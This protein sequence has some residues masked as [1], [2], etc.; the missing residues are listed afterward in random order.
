MATTATPANRITYLNGGGGRSLGDDADRDINSSPGL[1]ELVNE[2]NFYRFRSVAGSV[3]RGRR[4][5]TIVCAK[6]ACDCYPVSL[7]KRDD[8]TAPS[9]G[10]DNQRNA[11]E[12]IKNLEAFDWWVSIN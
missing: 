2:N 5:A 1:C 12:S 11:R 9:T 4:S 10:C 3:W 8:R 6:P 7:I